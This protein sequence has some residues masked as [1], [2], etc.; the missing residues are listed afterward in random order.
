MPAATQTPAPRQVVPP[1][2][3]GD[4]PGPR[5]PFTFTDWAMI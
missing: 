1:L 5:Q 3:H 4:K 2:T